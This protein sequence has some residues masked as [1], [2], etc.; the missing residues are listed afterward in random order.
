MSLVSKFNTL[1]EKS[2]IFGK[3]PRSNDSDFRWQFSTSFPKIIENH[4][5]Y[6]YMLAT[7]KISK[8]HPD[9]WRSYII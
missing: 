9:V 4:L 2:Q 8:A 3:S 1:K 5:L 7:S 6:E